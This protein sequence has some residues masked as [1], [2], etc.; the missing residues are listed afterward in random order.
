MQR[1]DQLKLLLPLKHLVCVELAVPMLSQIMGLLRTVLH[2]I[3]PL[4]F[5]KNMLGSTILFYLALGEMFTLEI[6]SHVSIVQ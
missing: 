1:G 4:S 2:F 6:I 3:L 5:L